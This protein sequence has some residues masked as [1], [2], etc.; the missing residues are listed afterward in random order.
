[1]NGNEVRRS[2]SARVLLADAPG[3][4]KKRKERGT[5][6]FVTVVGQFGAC[7]EGIIPKPALSP[8]G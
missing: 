8:A 5:L 2:S 3:P 4:R 6:P 1:M 7:F